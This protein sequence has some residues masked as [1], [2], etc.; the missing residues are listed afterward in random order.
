MPPLAWG[1]HKQFTEMFEFRVV[2]DASK[3]N[4]NFFL[5]CC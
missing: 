4:S 3:P 5:N 1:I 2:L